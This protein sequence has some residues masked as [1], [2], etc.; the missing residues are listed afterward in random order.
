VAIEEGELLR[1]VRRVIGWVEI[2]DD[3]VRASVEP[4]LMPRDDAR[5][6]LPPHRI[7][8]LDPS[9]VFEPRDRR[10]GSERRTADG[11]TSQQQLV[12][13]II[14]EAFGVIGIGMPTGHPEDPL[15]EQFAH[16]MAYLAGLPVIHQTRREV[17]EHSV[18]PF[19][20]GEH[21]GAP[22]RACML[23]I[24]GGNERL[25]AEIG[26]ENSLWYRI[27]GHRERLRR[28]QSVC[29]YRFYD[30]EAFVFL[31]ESARS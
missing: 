7:E 30:T 24:K 28:R 22:V 31:H 29:S 25:V 1:A 15:G 21:H 8:F 19:G 2:N 5:R 4:P 10:L 3:P 14:G 11:V 9:L 6:E 12:N 26:K 13:G 27:V 16:R 17:V 18:L 23:L 20:C